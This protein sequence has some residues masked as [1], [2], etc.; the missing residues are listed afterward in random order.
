MLLPQVNRLALASTLLAQAYSVFGSALAPVVFPRATVCN[1]HAEL[2]TRSYGNVSY[3]GAHDSYAVGVGLRK[4]TRTKPLL[5]LL[6]VELSNSCCQSR[7]KW[8][9]LQKSLVW[10]SQQLFLV[11][12]QL[13][14][15]IRLLQMQALNQSGTIELC[16]TSCVC[17]LSLYF[18]H[19]PNNHY[20]SLFDGG[21]L[22]DYLSTGI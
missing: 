22:Q 20:K 13:N 18:L 3:V 8:Y 12:Q 21:S 9:I 15:G 4:S 6:S 16:H 1:G 11:T 10:G 2:C 14:D 17:P 5:S 19:K 7:S